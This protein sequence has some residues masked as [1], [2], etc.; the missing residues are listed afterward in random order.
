LGGKL[1]VKKSLIKCI[2]YTDTKTYPLS[3]R[4]TS[5]PGGVC[6]RRQTMATDVLKGTNFQH[7]TSSYPLTP[8]VAIWVQL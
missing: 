4:W 7:T 3:F 6:N 1:F 2:Y 8:T 5:Q